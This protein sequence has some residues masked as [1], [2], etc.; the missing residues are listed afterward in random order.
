MKP[1]GSTRNIFLIGYRGT[2]KSTVAELVAAKLG[3]QYIDADAL[4]EERHSRSIA[5][6][7]ATEGEAGFR[8]KEAALLQ[9]LC[10]H[11]QRVVATGGGV[12]LRDAN[13][14]LLRGSGRC[15]WLTADPR[16][17]AKRMA[18][19]PATSARR[20]AL[21]TGGIAEIEELLKIREPLYRECADWTIDTAGRT[22]DEV[23]D[24]IV[25]K[26]VGT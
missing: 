26:V 16:T 21:T 20:P 24:M 19:D 7:F 14:A 1:S 22:P 8:D 11:R 5:Q 25:E 23:A 2:G 13:R 15:I 18:G 10:C 17:I 9:E 4:L 3:L 6:I 12:I